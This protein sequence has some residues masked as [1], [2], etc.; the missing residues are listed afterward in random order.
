VAAHVAKEIPVGFAVL[1]LAVSKAD[2]FIGVGRK[3][4]RVL[5]RT[6]LFGLGSGQP[7]PL[8]ARNLTPPAG[9]A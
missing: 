1:F 2:D 9:G 4:L 3:V 6:D 5:V 7:I 8:F